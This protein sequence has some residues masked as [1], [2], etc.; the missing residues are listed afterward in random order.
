MSQADDLN[1]EINQLLGGDINVI[2]TPAMV[3]KVIVIDARPTNTLASNG[4][5]FT[6]ALNNVIN[7]LFSSTDPVVIQQAS[8]SIQP[9]RRSDDATDV[10]L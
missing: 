3:G 5:G 2:G 7:T 6:A 9:D 10:R 8:R 4:A 1:N